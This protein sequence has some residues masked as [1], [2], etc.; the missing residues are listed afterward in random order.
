MLFFG[1]AARSLAITWLSRRAMSHGLRVIDLSGAWRLKEEQHRAIYG[2]QDSDTT[3]A[4]EL[5][6]RAVYGLPELNG[7]RSWPMPRWSPIPA[8]MPLR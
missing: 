5:T 3:M 1:D 7:D 4:A 8:A 2:F 6:D